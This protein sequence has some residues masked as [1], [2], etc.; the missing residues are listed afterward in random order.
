MVSGTGHSA[1]G[2]EGR[3]S[4]LER[5]LTDPSCTCLLLLMSQSSGAAGLNLTAASAAY[6]LEPA[7]NPG[8]EAQAAAR[9]YRMGQTKPTRLVSGR[10]CAPGPPCR[11]RAL[12]PAGRREARAAAADQRPLP[13]SPCA[14]AAG[15][16]GL[17]GAARA[18][19]AAVEAGARAGA[20]RQRGAGV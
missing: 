14:G 19:D 6:I 11:A 10:G 20:R 9:V 17:C 12:L 8:L 7:P 15:G 4:E 18:G 3:Q 16:G 5:F 1:A 2:L 13:R